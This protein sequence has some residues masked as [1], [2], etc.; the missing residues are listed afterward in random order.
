M[1]DEMMYAIASLLP[2]ERRGV[3]GDLSRATQDTL[4]WL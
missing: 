1:T 3:Y 4:E 2:P